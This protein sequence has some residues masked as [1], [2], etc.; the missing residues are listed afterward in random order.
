MGSADF[1]VKLE[2]N[3]EM[4][5]RATQPTR[6][7]GARWSRHAHRESQR[8][9]REIRHRADARVCESALSDFFVSTFVKLKSALEKIK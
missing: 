9:P 5:V 2:C 7:C 8:E 1:E 3:L 6:G 4:K